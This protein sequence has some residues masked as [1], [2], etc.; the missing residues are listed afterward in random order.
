MST[1]VNIKNKRARFEYDLLDVYTAGMVLQGSEIKSI[2]QSKA[3]IAEGYC[4][5]EGDELFILNMNI[6]E[7][8]KGG[9]ANHAPTRKRKLLL[10]RQE[11]EKIRKKLKDTGITVVPLRL[12]IGSAGYAKLEIALAKGKKL[13]DKREDLKQKDMKRSIDRFMK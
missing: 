13:F 2:R 6:A 7:Y 12:F 8:E 5:F 11:L 1:N 9:Y 3:S 10:N 4:A